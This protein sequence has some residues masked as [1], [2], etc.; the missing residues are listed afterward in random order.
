MDA[1]TLKQLANRIFP[2]ADRIQL[3]VSGEPLVR[4]LDDVLELAAHHGVRIEINTNA[5]RLD[6]RMLDAL[7]P[8][9]GVVVVSFDGATKATFERIREGARFEVVLEN[10]RRLCQRVREL[11]A[12][13]RPLIQLQCTLMDRNVRELPDLV[14]LT[15]ELGAHRLLCHHLHP[16]HADMKDQSL[17]FHRPLAAHWIG[18]ALERARERGLPMV[19]EGLGSIA[20][21][22]AE[23]ADIQRVISQQEGPDEVLDHQ[24]V[25]QDRVPPIPTLP[26]GDTEAVARV[27]A[28]RRAALAGSS[29]PVHSVQ[30]P[31]PDGEGESDEPSILTCDY[32]WNRMLVGIHGEVRPCCVP[33]NPVLGSV[34]DHELETVWNGP[35]YRA[36]R[37]RIVRKDPAAFCRGCHFLREVRGPAAIAEWIGDRTIPAP[38]PHDE[39]TPV[40][41]GT[42]HAAGTVQS[43]HSAPQLRWPMLEG[44]SGYDLELSADRFT[45][46]AFASSE[47][48]GRLRSP[49]YSIPEWAWRL[50]PLNQEVHWRAIAD[51]DGNFVEVAYGALRRVE[52]GR[53]A[54]AAGR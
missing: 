3:S 25:H 15:V 26:V 27:R 53:G 4:K 28:R 14:D 54:A 39:L 42:F 45:T 33:G 19:V 31:A 1:A 37:R 32:L 46:V 10:T 38:D 20:A 44:A 12:E 41:V 29:F 23:R 11:P 8:H 50:A 18:L 34:M 21:E 43:S 35:L 13:Q 16:F 6:E 47:H 5:T 36:L 30:P 7:L 51:F 49:E 48:G 17:A 9:L 2:F 24:E 22:S 52:S 40:L